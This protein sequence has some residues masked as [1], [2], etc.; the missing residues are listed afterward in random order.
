MV[1]NSRFTEL[2]ADIEPSASRVPSSFGQEADIDPAARNE[3][4]HGQH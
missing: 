2:L 1:P 3:S 4:L